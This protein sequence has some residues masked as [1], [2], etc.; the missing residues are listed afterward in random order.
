VE[1]TPRA[2]RIADNEA[3]FRD[4]NDRLEAGLRQ[5]PH[6]PERLDFVCECGNG[7]CTASISV[8]LDEY[9]AVR[10]DSRHFLVL[11]G[12]VFRETE[13]VIG[14]TDRYEVV[15]K[16]GDVVALTD[17]SDP[18]APGTGGIRDGDAKPE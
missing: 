1:I 7:D 8:T 4:I 6:A 18:R 16:F 15:E 2:R 13:R 17:A 11:P 12:H 14:G 3:V 9:A 10:R 5:V